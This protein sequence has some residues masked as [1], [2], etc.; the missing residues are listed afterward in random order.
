MIQKIC[1]FTL[2][3]NESNF[4]EQAIHAAIIIIILI[5]NQIEE[6]IAPKKHKD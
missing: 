3:L 2:V 5:A 6:V 1:I 4:P